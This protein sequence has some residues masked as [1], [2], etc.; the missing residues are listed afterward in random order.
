MRALKLGK[1]GIPKVTRLSALVALFMPSVKPLEKGQ[2]K[3][4]VC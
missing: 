3:D 4:D 1:L 2:S